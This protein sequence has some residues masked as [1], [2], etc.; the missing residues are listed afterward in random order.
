MKI[1]IPDYRPPSLNQY[2]GKH[3]S[4][5]HKMKKQCKELVLA[6]SRHIPAATGR[7]SVQMHVVLGKGMRQHDADN[8]QKLILDALVHAGMLVDD[9]PKWVEFLGVTYERGVH[10]TIISLEDLT[11]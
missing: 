4:I 11:G 1:T 7:R 10:Q 8:T 3:W 2:I 9:S 5:G 6:Y